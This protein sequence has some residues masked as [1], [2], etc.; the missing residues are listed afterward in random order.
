[1]TLAPLVPPLVSFLA[2]HPL[3]DKF[4][5]SSLK[6]IS[7]GAAPLSRDL[8]VKVAERIPNLERVA[9]GKKLSHQKFCLL[10]VLYVKYQT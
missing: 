8:E 2:K 1:M 4:D 6:A 10:S 9:Q 7:S 3:V 5:L